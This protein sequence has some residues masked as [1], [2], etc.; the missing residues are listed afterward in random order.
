MDG[1]VYPAISDSVI[2]N[3][4]VPY[5]EDSDEQMRIGKI[6]NQINKI[7]KQLREE[8]LLLEKIKQGLINMLYLGKL[9]ID[10]DL[11]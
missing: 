6:F 5:S 2:E 7:L 8:I 9:R 3:T 1:M 11:T 4:L 10:D